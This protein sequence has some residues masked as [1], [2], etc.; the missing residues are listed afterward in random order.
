VRAPFRCIDWT[1]SVPVTVLSLVLTRLHSLP[2]AALLSLSTPK[3]R[4]RFPNNSKKAPS[5]K[6]ISHSSEEERAR[7]KNS[8]GLLMGVSNIKTVGV[9]FMQAGRR[10]RQSGKFWRRRCVSICAIR[11]GSQHSVENLPSLPSQA[12]PY[13]GKQASAEAAPSCAWK[14]VMLPPA[15]PLNIN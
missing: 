1:R 10:P 12:A 3:L 7:S 14:C 8:L 15:S 13:H 6:H 5:R 4:G 9:K 2:Q 11:I